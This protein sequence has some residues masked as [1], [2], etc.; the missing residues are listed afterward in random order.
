MELSG[1]TGSGTPD[2]D[3]LQVVTEIEISKL[4]WSQ[5]SGS[6]FITVSQDV[7]SNTLL[8]FR[9]T[10]QNPAFPQTPRTVQVH[11]PK[12][13][14]PVENVA[15]Q[16]TTNASKQISSKVSGKVLGGERFQQF[17]HAVVS[18]GNSMARQWNEIQTSFR[19]DSALPFAS[20]VV[21][22]GLQ[23]AQNPDS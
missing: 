1:L 10:L 21:I 4:R 20:R 14:L 18:E 5:R 13:A 22:T 11:V 17:E 15:T 6:V 8:K 2:T 16:P 12:P 9:L 3:S 7:I 19:P 23:G